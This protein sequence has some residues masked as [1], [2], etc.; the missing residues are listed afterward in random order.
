MKKLA[1]GRQ[2]RITGEAE[3][4]ETMRKGKSYA[5]GHLVLYVLKKAS[6][7][8]EG[9]APPG[10]RRFTRFGISLQ[11][12]IGKAVVR[13]RIKRWTREVFR[14]HQSRLKEAVDMVLIV[15][16]SAREIVDYFEMEERILNLWERARIVRN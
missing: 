3:F 9:V 15:R 16:Y 5:D 1:L 10:E 4:R 2:Q 14:L 8:P 13:N 6:D 11:R 7:R 12:R